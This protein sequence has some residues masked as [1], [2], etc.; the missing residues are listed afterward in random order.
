MTENQRTR[1]MDSEFSFYE[2]ADAIS[3][4]TELLDQ[5]AEMLSKM[6]MREVQ[7]MQDKKN[8]L[9]GRLELQQGYLNAAP[10]T[11]KKL[12]NQQVDQLRQYSTKFNSSMKIYGEELY[13]ASKVNEQ[14]VEIIVDTVKEQVKVENTYQNFQNSKA[15]RQSDTYMPAIKFNE[16]I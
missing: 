1:E 14:V 10:N 16:Q 15:A 8:E 9:S 5:E 12:S 13:K 6:Q 2:F 4:M 3:S 11:F 7:E